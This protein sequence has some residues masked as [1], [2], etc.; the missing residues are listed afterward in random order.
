MEWNDSKIFGSGSVRF[1]NFRFRFSSIPKMLVPV[2]FDSSTMRKF[3]LLH[4]K[5]MIKMPIFSNITQFFLQKTLFWP[6]IEIFLTGTW[7]RGSIGSGPLVPVR[8]GSEKKSLVLQFYEYGSRFASTPIEK[9]NLGPDWA[10]NFRVWAKPSLKFSSPSRAESKNF[11]SESS[12]FQKWAILAY[13]FFRDE[14]KFVTTW[15][16]Q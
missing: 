1:Q 6:I 8:F 3:L 10:Q 14:Y 2:R 5:R 15:R 11:E 9:L 7:N 4:C 12:H 16:T 13:F